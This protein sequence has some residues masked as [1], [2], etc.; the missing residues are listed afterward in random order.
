MP[1]YEY[2]C[3]GCETKFEKRRSMSQADEAI[4]CPACGDMRASRSLSLFAAFSRGSN[5]ES[6]AVSGSGGCASC[7]THACGSCKHH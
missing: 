7:G 1:I 6:Q 4:T 2:H 5:G 3:A